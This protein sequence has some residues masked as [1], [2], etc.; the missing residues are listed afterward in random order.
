M[1][2]LHKCNLCEKEFKRR[3]YLTRHLKQAHKTSSNS[4]TF[5]QIADCVSTEQSPVLDLSN[6]SPTNDW[7][8]VDLFL[9]SLEDIPIEAP[10]PGSYLAPSNAVPSSTSMMQVSVCTQTDTCALPPI[11]QPHSIGTNTT[12]VFRKDKMT[13]EGRPLIDGGNSPHC[14]MVS[15]HQ[16]YQGWDSPDKNPP[17]TPG[18]D[19]PRNYTSSYQEERQ[20]MNLPEAISYQGPYMEEDPLPPH[21]TPNQPE[22]GVVNRTLSPNFQLMDYLENI[23]GSIT[24]PGL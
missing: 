15:P 21:L 2:K 11:R 3:E 24:P 19:L 6:S 1:H 17:R 13:Q 8:D 10:L 23:C 9:N 7:D 5:S 16:G 14:K 4:R 22:W 12:P 20:R 18:W